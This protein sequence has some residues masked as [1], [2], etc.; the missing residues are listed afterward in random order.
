MRQ[1]D[2]QLQRL[3]SLQVQQVMLTE[4]AV[5]AV[6]GGSTSKLITPRPQQTVAV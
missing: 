3:A 5:A 2:A 4:R 1:L 6:G